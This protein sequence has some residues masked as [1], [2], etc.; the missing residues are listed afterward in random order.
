MFDNDVIDVYWIILAFLFA[1]IIFIVITN[2]L[3]YVGILLK[4]LV[5]YVVMLSASVNFVIKYVVKLIALS[6]VCPPY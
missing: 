6:V 4:L 2:P 3:A 5:A 1:Y